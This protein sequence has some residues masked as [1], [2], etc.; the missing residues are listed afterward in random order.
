[1]TLTA[2][3]GRGD[4]QIHEEGFPAAGGDFLPRRRNTSQLADFVEE[5]SLV[6]WYDLCQP[7][8]V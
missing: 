6:R 3:L 7:R 8:D 4:E 5:R 1:M 2:N